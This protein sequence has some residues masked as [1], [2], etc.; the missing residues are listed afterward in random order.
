MSTSPS[1]YIQVSP[2]EREEVYVKG[3]EFI[4]YSDHEP[5]TRLHT[6]NEIINKRY[7]WIEYLQELGTI[8]KY[9]PGKDNVVADFITHNLKHERKL[10]VLQCSSLHLSQS[11]LQN[12]EILAVQRNAPELTKI[13]NYL[14]KK[15]VA[16]KMDVSPIFH[17]HLDHLELK[18]N[19]LIYKRNVRSYCIVAPA[20]MTEQIIKLCH[21]DWASGHFGLYKSHRR[22]LQRFRWPT[23]LDD[24]NNLLL[25]V[26]SV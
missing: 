4:V 5:L 15:Q 24:L 20:E 2:R 21:S 11:I 6:A 26:R 8:V 12:D 19:L 1:S 23:C 18:G 17:R 7:R 9:L 22:I 14:L 3:H 13:I 25:I 10:N 16:N